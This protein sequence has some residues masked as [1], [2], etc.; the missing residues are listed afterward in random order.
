LQELHWPLLGSNDPNL[1]DSIV[2]LG[3]SPG[4]AGR[5]PKRLASLNKKSQKEVHAYPSDHHWELD[6]HQ[7]VEH[8]RDFQT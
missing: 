6:L 8:P 2:V 7:E 3:E 1:S 4:L 5:E